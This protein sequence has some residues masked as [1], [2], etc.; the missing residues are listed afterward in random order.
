[1]RRYRQR[2]PL[3]RACRAAGPGIARVLEAAGAVTVPSGPGRRA[4]AGEIV[5]AVRATT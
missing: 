2:G 3:P 1:M 4:S 5:A